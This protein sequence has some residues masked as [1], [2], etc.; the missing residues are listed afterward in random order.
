MTRWIKLLA[1]AVPLLAA[2]FALML[3]A[4]RRRKA[5]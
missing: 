3:F 5:G 4:T 1:A 2:G